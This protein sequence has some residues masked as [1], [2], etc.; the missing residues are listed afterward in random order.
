MA[1]LGSMK[2][3]VASLTSSR[4][5]AALLVVIF[6]FGLNVWP[7]E[8]LQKFFT[9][10]N[11]AVSFFFVLSGFVMVYTYEYKEIKFGSYFKKRLARIVPVY[12][13][14]LVL[15]IILPLYSWAVLD[16][17]LPENFSIN[18]LLHLTFLQT[19]IP[20]HALTLNVPAWSLSI[21]MFFYVLFPFLLIW[22]RNNRISFLRMSIAVFII[23]QAIHLGLI[24]YYNGNTTSAVHDLIYY[25]PIWHINEFLFGMCG[26]YFFQRMPAILFRSTTLPTLVVVLLITYVPRSISLHNGLLAPFFL[27]IILSMLRKE[28]RLMKWAPLVFLGE[29]SYGIYILQLP[30]YNYIKLCNDNILHLNNAVFFWV[31]LGVLIVIATISYY[32]IETP[33]RRR[34]LA[35]VKK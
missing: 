7:F 8:S 28:R 18:L 24:A 27:L 17:D 5:I 35:Y 21:E 16:T 34:I 14:A 19:F 11:Y 4:A 23:S 10:G 2:N 6:H 13:L 20:G 30:I 33:I 32:F 12:L 29:V 25:F 1:I 26:L 9:G 31:Y 15:F 22:Y 3:K